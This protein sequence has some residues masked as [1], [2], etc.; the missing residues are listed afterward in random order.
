MNTPSVARALIAILA[1]AALHV[2]TGVSASEVTVSGTKPAASCT[3]HSRTT[4]L[5]DSIAVSCDGALE[6]PN[7]LLVAALSGLQVQV[8]GEDGARYN[9]VLDGD[10]VILRLDQN[11]G[12][13]GT[14]GNPVAND[15]G[16]VIVTAGGPAKEIPVLDNDDD[17]ESDYLYIVDASGAVLGQL[18]TTDDKQALVYT[19]PASVSEETDEILSYFAADRHGGKSL[20]PATVTV[21]IQPDDE[22][23][24]VGN[25]NKTTGA[26]C[27]GQ[28]AD[29][30]WY[31]LEEETSGQVSGTLYVPRR[32]DY[33]TVV[34]DNVSTESFWGCG[35]TGAIIVS[36]PGQ[37]D[38]NKSLAGDI[39]YAM[40]LP[41]VNGITPRDSVKVATVNTAQDHR[42]WL[43]AVSTHP[44]NLNPNDWNEDPNCG[45]SN[46]TGG[47]DFSAPYEFFGKTY[48]GC[49]LLGD[50]HFSN[51]LV[52]IYVKVEPTGRRSDDCG[53]GVHAC[54]MYVKS[55]AAKAS[56]N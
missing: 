4:V 36:L 33:D 31:S 10:Q 54:R 5:P 48:D 39:T 11:N 8:E 3:A 42:D 2:S 20:L 18:W 13:G 6:L 23:G 38:W 51:E 1:G 53:N 29:G 50:G 44:T 9:A 55:W 52:N 25:C 14:N 7:A 47:A 15:D 40:R 32:G 43:I 56:A 21:T 41:I 28:T 17:P 19:P 35:P 22:R 24:R 12:G 16:P 37:C 26:G 46:P 34:Y 27:L 45:S 30:T 49:A